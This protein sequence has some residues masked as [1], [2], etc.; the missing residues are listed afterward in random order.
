MLNGRSLFFIIPVSLS[1]VDIILTCEVPVFPEIEN[2]LS[3]DLLFHAVPFAV[4]TTLYIDFL[5]I[6]KC[7]ILKLLNFF[8]ELPD[9][10]FVDK[11]L[12]ILGSIILPSLIKFA[13]IIANSKGVD[14]KKPC[15]IP[16][17]KVSP[18]C[19]FSS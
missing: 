19:H 8:I 9:I 11:V 10:A 16:T 1:F 18:F 4:L 13:V 17:F 5:I 2:S 15:P 3:I 7:S 14:N 12:T 6:F